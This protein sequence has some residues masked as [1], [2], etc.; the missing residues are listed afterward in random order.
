MITQIH[1]NAQRAISS[2]QP[3]LHDSLVIAQRM[4]ATAEPPIADDAAQLVATLLIVNEEVDNAKAK[5]STEAISDAAKALSVGA[6]EF[7]PPD[8]S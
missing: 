4:L 8:S 7:Q 5:I 2:I 3:G 1:G 6:R